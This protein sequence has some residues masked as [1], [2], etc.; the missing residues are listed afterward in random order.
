[1]ES[2]APRIIDRLERELG[3]DRVKHRAEDRLHYA[4]DESRLP[5]E[6]ICG[7]RPACED[8]VRTVLDIARS[9]GVALVPRGAGTSTTGSALPRRGQVVLDMSGMNRIL[10]IDA[11]D[12][13][14]VVEP[15]VR[16]GDLQEAAA[17]RGLF[18]PP[19]PASAD[20]STLGGN[21]ATNAG[22]LRALKYGVT[23]DYVLGLRAV[24][25]SGQVIETGGRNLK[26]VVGY[27]L[28]RLLVGSEGT[29]AIFT[30]LILRLIPLPAT[31]ATVLASFADDGG[32]F[33]GADAVLAAGILP[34]ALEYLD[35][36]VLEI[37]AARTRDHL[38]PRCRSQLLI[39]VDGGAEQVESDTGSLLRIL[40]DAGAMEAHHARD[41]AEREHLWS[42]RRAVSTSVRDAAAAKR[43]EDLGVP[44]G[45]LAAAVAAAK[46]AG[47]R[48]GIR[49]LAYGHAGDANLHFNFLYDPSH[50]GEEERLEAAVRE[51]QHLVGELGGTISGEHGIG[52]K[53][54]DAM[55]RST[56]PG[57]V[58]IMRGIKGLFDPQGIL[59]PGKALPTTGLECE[60]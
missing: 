10:D 17:A 52:L 25:G 19:D 34:R 48:H 60:A 2:E 38:D 12:Q 8:E 37:V 28:T 54:R 45:R 55:A 7:V 32:G 42:A 4:Q 9:E 11:A 23:R 58:R 41:P 26:D 59:N 30:R 57:L 31:S 14:A 35:R 51:C 56:E 50:P 20:T 24:C 46:E 49:V 33:R 39:E 36:D 3:A 29:L 6:C 44:R 15:G 21:V 5:G 13:V 22:G 27:D 53:K 1:M 47:A 18:Y 40:Q 16:C 43:S